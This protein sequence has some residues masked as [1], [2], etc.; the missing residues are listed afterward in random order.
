[1]K[2]ITALALAALMGTTAAPALAQ[3]KGDMLLGLGLGWVEPG[4][5]GE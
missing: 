4:D 3:E 1:M 2:R 5:S